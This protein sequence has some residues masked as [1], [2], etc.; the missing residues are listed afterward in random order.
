MRR[1]RGGTQ[2]DSN[3]QTNDDVVQI[4]R[5]LVHNFCITTENLLKTNV[6]LPSSRLGYLPSGRQVCL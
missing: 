6:S 1:S 5:D 2:H 4:K 3:A